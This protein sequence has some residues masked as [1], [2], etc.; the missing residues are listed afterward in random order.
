MNARD[1]ILAAIRKG[2]GTPRPAPDAIAAEAAALRAFELV[3]LREVGVLPELA[4]ETL[5]LQALRADRRYTL[6]AE[7]GLVVHADGLGADTWVALEA[8]LKHGHGGALR[9]ACTAA[10][11]AL[12][13]PLRGLLDYHLGHARLRTRDV[14]RGLQKLTESAAP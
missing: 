7:A 5:T 4:V 3:L 10:S 13:A 1:G 2:L 12:R 9:A 8:A 14:M 6:D 11:V